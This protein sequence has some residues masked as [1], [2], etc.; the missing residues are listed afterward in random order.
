[1]ATGRS[2]LDPAQ[3]QRAVEIFERLVDLPPAARERV[4]DA[5]AEGEVD[6]R[7]TLRAMFAADE[8][9]NDLIDQGIEPL[10]HLAGTM[11]I[12]DEAPLREGDQVGDF[13]IIAEIGRGGMGIVYAARDRTLGRVAALKLLPIAVGADSS[14]SERL[15]AEAQSASALDHPNVATIYQIGTTTDGH[16]FIAMARYEGETLRDRLARGAIPP[17]DA[18]DIARQVA[19]GLAAA[20]EA[21]LVH[22]DVKPENIFI[23]RDGLVKLLDF[24][25]ATLASAAREGSTTRGTLRYMSPEHARCEAPDS[26]SDVW[27]LGVVLYEMIAGKPPFKGRTDSHTRVSII[28]HEPTPLVEHVPDVPRQLERIVTKALAKDKLKRYQT[29]TDLKLDLDQLRDGVHTTSG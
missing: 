11:D 4:L 21:G 25:I 26:R 2:P 6:L 22:R 18:F 17:R 20:H 13:V 14:A 5:E 15:V 19:A 27:S 9:T 10:A 29:I 7:A 23:T 16:R 12:R 28:D 3:W 1:L 8:D 24:G